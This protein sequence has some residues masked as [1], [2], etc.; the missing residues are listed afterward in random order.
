MDWH[1]IVNRWTSYSDQFK[2]S[3]GIANR[4]LESAKADAG[5]P[6]NDDRKTGVGGSDGIVHRDAAAMS[7][8]IE[9]R[10]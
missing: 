5:H 9:W 2:A 6:R 4:R 1:R 8:H 3:W 7:V 10:P